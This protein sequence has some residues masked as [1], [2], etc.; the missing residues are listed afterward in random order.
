MAQGPARCRS[1]P[2][3]KSRQTKYNSRSNLPPTL[4]GRITW[5]HSGSLLT[6]TLW[7]T[8]MR[9][10]GKK[11]EPTVCGVTSAGIGIISKT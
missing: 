11:H 8:L 1:E 6:S 3:C 7:R 2:N 5:N 9:R 10:E 4:L